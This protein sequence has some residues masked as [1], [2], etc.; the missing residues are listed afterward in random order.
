ML[1]LSPVFKALGHETQP[2]AIRMF[3][4]T[5][6]YTVFSILKMKN[7][8]VTEMGILNLHMASPFPPLN[9]VARVCMILMTQIGKQH[10]NTVR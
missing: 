8:Q 10:G 4:A 9:P 1:I 3:K 7:E 2:E 5:Q 6:S